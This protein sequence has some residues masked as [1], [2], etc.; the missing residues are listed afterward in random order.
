M[1]TFSIPR[2]DYRAFPFS[3][4][5]DGVA[6]NIAGYTFVFTLKKNVADDD[7]EILFEEI[8]EIPAGTAV[9][10][11]LLEISSEDS[12]QEPGT[13][14]LEGSSYTDVTQP[15]T[16]DP[17]VFKITERERKDMPEEETP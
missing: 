17:V 3:M 4:E 15:I 9:Y 11:S 16:A 1:K 10:S 12:D 14:W 8:I 5:V 2:A 13:Y 6:Q 7:T